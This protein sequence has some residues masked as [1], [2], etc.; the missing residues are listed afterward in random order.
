MELDYIEKMCSL[1]D[2]YS[3]QNETNR[4]DSAS[5]PFNMDYESNSTLTLKVRTDK[6][7][8]YDM[9]SDLTD[10]TI[11]NLN[12]TEVLPMCEKFLKKFQSAVTFNFLRYN[13][14]KYLYPMLL[15]FG[16]FG[17]TLSFLVMIKVFRSKKKGLDNRNFSF[18]L[19][20][21][22]LSDCLILFFG[23]FRE[24]LEEI[25]NISIWSSSI[26]S[27]K[28]VYF[29]CYLFSSFSANLY[30]FI[31]FER[32]QAVI[33]PLR[34]KQINIIKNQKL[35]FGIF[36]YCFVIS[37]P[38][39]V[40]PSIHK[41]INPKKNAPNNYSIETK[42]DISHN[43][44]LSDVLIMLLDSLFYCFIPFLITFI[45][46]I[47]TWFKLIT[48][49]RA[50]N[51]FEIHRNKVD[52][53]AQKQNSRQTYKLKVTVML[54]A[55]TVSYMLTTAPIFV[56]ILLQL[57]FNH[58][59]KNSYNYETEYACSKVFMYINNS[60][61]ILFVILFGKNLRRDF[62]NIFT[63]KMCKRKSRTETHTEI[64]TSDIQ[65]R[66]SLMRKLNK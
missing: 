56:I 16:L 29:G 40:F 63:F 42:C 48:D 39:L 54:Y 32:Y 23:C 58:M 38:F 19:A 2:V 14:I 17:N 30:A 35:I 61:N 52:N 5:W 13:L 64:S 65:L 36:V 10:M 41:S 66:R 50:S 49:R 62:V 6:Y 24:F 11:Q 55:Y 1:L 18:C 25:F 26:Y 22:C 43:L 21:L 4:R 8:A 9:S 53:R 47:L 7:E 31:A 51:Q 34:Y 46:S 12:L 37:L 57:Y 20:M 15:V 45:F 27:C 44:I 59:L 3:L 60:I 33:S 28:L